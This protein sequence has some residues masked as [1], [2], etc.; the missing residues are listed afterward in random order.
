MN[1]IYSA[2][3]FTSLAD[4]AQ[5]CPDD[6]GS[7]ISQR[8]RFASAWLPRAVARLFD[9][10]LRCYS[11]DLFNAFAAMCRRT[12]VQSQHERGDSN[13]RDVRCAVRE[14]VRIGKVDDDV[15]AKLEAVLFADE[16]QIPEID[17]RTSAVLLE[18]VKDV[19]YEMHVRPARFTAA[20]RVRRFFADEHAARERRRRGD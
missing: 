7:T 1:A 13:G 8:D 12:L 9:E 17:E 20:L 3:R 11:A 5:E 4:A 18:V 19:L 6:E 14:I 2:S 15:T 10:A 16:H